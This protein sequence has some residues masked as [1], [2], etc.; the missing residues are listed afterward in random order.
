MIPLLRSGAWRRAVQRA[1]TVLLT[2][3]AAGAALAQ[4]QT[5]SVEFQELG[6]QKS[7]TLQG[8][9]GWGGL[10]FGVR[11][12]ERVESLRLRLKLRHSDALLPKLSHLNVR[13][14]GLVIQALP[15]LPVKGSADHEYVVDLP[16]DRLQALNQL[17]LQQ[18]GHYTMSC[19]DPLHESLWTRIDDRSALE[20]TV[21]PRLLPDDLSLLPAPFFDQRDS[22]RLNVTVV[23]PQRSQA[24]IQGAGMVA[25]WLGALGGYRGA[26]FAV[27]D[28]L[29]A[30]GPAIV[31][32][33][34]GQAGELAG[35]AVRGPTLLMKN[36]PND[37]V[38][39]VL[40]VT[41]ANE[42]EL[43]T[44]ARSL[45]TG[46]DALSGPT[47]SSLVFSARERKPYDAP[48]WVPS[49][50]PVK[51]GELVA[52]TAMT[53]SGYRPESINVDLRLPPDLYPWLDQRVPMVLR[54]RP[55]MTVSDP[56]AYL[57]V[58]VNYEP[59]ARLD[60]DREAHGF[61]SLAG[62]DILP[63]TERAIRLPLDLL[64]TR[65]TLGFSFHYPLPAL[66]DC[67]NLGV[68]NV[69][70]SLD[71]D[72]SLDFSGLPHFL[73]MPNAG[74]FM[75]AGY[76]F[77]R[78]ADLSETVVVL[79]SEVVSAELSAYLGL[80]AKIGQSTG[81]PATQV[82]VVIDPASPDGMQDKDILILSS[83][84]PAAL[85][86]QW[87]AKLPA[88]GKQDSVKQLLSGRDVLITGFRSPLSRSRNVVVLSTQGDLGEGL[89]P[90][91]REPLLEA[92]VQG[93]MVALSGGDVRVLSEQ[94]QY[95]T[96]NLGWWRGL[97][98]F[99]GSNP[100]LLVL[101][102]IGGISLASLM[103]YIS[104]RARARSRLRIHASQN[105]E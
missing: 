2:M 5:Y 57:A 12:D 31:L 13:L 89:L 84:K 38:S 58:D 94:T 9:D 7:M 33:T 88:A 46:S 37:G 62:T 85:L 23:L 28:Q 81:Y 40:L 102:F 11:Q 100:W 15:Y 6:R 29:P 16:V 42:Q 105:Q 59:V 87:A 101:I 71:P 70:S 8:V 47:A 80:M 83:G 22:R 72:S 67:E 95:H 36:N 25:S 41:G 39:K 103:A 26:D 92:K 24:A 44:A 4:P 52:D 75:A 19:E 45:V 65:A 32:A 3:A 61:K 21:A 43:L 66:N 97:Q 60:F 1:A 63:M 48:N 34:A 86:E 91:L 76:P 50:R 49:D 30:Q 77:S 18:I 20:F 64:A 14:N 82:Q 99:L 27:R 73:A 68:N 10:W 35:S 55:S 17:Q 96:G 104:L 93:S 78:L 69:R 98:Y 74:A 51:F 90:V 79:S 56:S 54:Y 53:V